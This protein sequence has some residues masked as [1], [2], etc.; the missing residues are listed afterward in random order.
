MGVPQ[1]NAVGST[2]HRAFS[3]IS[4]TK[5]PLDLKRSRVLSIQ[6]PA[7]EIAFLALMMRVVFRVKALPAVIAASFLILG[8]TIPSSLHPS[9]EV[10]WTNVLALPPVLL[11]LAYRPFPRCNRRCSCGEM[12]LVPRA[13]VNLQEARS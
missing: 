9:K 11:P 7:G 3:P 10:R 13:G 1:V 12:R 5:I 2:R 4:A 8:A 6:H